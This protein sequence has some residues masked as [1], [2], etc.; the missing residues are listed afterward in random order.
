MGT[1]HQ[2][3]RYTIASNISLREHRQKKNKKET[4]TLYWRHTKSQVL[5][6]SLL[7]KCKKCKDAKKCKIT[8]VCFPVWTTESLIRLNGVGAL[9]RNICV[10]YL[11]IQNVTFRHSQGCTTSVE[12]RF[13]WRNPKN[14]F[15]NRMCN[16]KRVLIQW[17]QLIC[18]L[19]QLDMYVQETSSSWRRKIP[20]S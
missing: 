9:C 3:P 20:R 7:K 19:T 8:P 2:G 15:Y 12:L 11:I 13:L 5:R 14:P 4:R 18:S 6:R 16:Y 10:S 1:A 17:P